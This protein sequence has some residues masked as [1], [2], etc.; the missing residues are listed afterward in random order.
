[1]GTDTT[2]EEGQQMKG[3]V[4]KKGKRRSKKKFGC[5]RL[6]GQLPRINE[7]FTPEKRN[8]Q[9][10]KM[11]IQGPERVFSVVLYCGLC[12]LGLTAGL[13]GEGKPPR[14]RSCVDE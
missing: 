11:M 13:A 1:M 14:R 4:A 9:D 3:R 8:R 5:A 6:L 7:Q 2:K 12:G 10:C